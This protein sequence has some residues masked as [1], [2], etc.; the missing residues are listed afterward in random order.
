[1]VRLRLTGV[2]IIELGTG[3][4]QSH[5]GAIATDPEVQKKWERNVFQSHYGAIAT[6]IYPYSSHA[7]VGTFQSHYGAIA[8]AQAL[9]LQGTEGW[10]Q[11]HYGAIATFYYAPIH[12]ILFQVSIPLWCDC[13][14]GR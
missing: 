2:N 1:M 7:H 11:S 9:G 12:Y 5:Y 6:K 13:D 3:K 10:F 8:T 4:F 14:N